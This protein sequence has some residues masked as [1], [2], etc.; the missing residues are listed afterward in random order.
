MRYELHIPVSSIVV[1][2]SIMDSAHASGF[3]SASNPVGVV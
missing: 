1:A 3:T 2:E